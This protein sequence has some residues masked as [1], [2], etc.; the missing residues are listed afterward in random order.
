MGGGGGWGWVVARGVGGR[1]RACWGW[2]SSKGCL[3]V[4]VWRGERGGGW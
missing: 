3:M 2:G 1:M 4:C